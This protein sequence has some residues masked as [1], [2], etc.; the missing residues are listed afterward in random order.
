M[1]H[2]FG[3]LSKIDVKEYDEL[4]PGEYAVR[5]VSLDMKATKNNGERLAVQFEVIEGQHKGRLYF[6][7]FNLV[8]ANPQAVQIALQDIKRWLIAAGLHAEAEQPLTLSNIMKL[9][10]RP[11]VIALKP[12]KNGDGMNIKKFMP[13]GAGVAAAGNYAPAQPPTQTQQAAPVAQNVYNPN[14]AGLGGKRSRYEPLPQEQY[15]KEQAAQKAA[16][17]DA[18]PP[19][20]VPPP[21]QRAQ[22]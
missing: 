5:A 16:Q 2:S 7:G 8:N 3:D 20:D 6:D 18:P 17:T 21:W 9:D 12:R 15:Y 19:V 13:Y 10:G 1:N 22:Q 11:L 14:L 4:P